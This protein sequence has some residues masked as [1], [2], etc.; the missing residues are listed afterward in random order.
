M[1]TF[2]AAALNPYPLL[3]RMWPSFALIFQEVTFVALLPWNRQLDT[4][5]LVSS[6][7]NVPPIVALFLMNLLFLIVKTDLRPIQKTPPPLLAMFPW[8]RHPVIVM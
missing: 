8:K 2:I 4:L 7:T 1:Q 3:F 5:E 6:P